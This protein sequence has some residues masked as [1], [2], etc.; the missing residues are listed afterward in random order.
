MHKL[1]PTKGGSH[2]EAD[3]KIAHRLLLLLD[4]KTANFTVSHREMLDGSLLHEK[5]TAAA[6]EHGLPDLP[7]VLEPGDIK[8]L[9][10]IVQATQLKPALRTA[11]PTFLGFDRGR[12]HGPNFTATSRGVLFRPC[13][14]AAN[15]RWIHPENPWDPEHDHLACRANELATWVAALEPSERLM[16]SVII[17]AALAWLQRG[18]RG[19]PSFVLL[20]SDAH[21]ELLGA[22]TGLV[23]IEVGR[24]PRLQ[25]GVPRLM[26]SS[27][28]RPDQFEKHGRIVAALEDRHRRTNPRIPIVL[29][30]W[31]GTSVPSPPAGILALLTH[32]V[33]GTTE[34]PSAV[35]RLISLVECPE[36]RRNFQPELLKAA[37]Y[38][39]DT[40]RYLDTFLAAARKLPDLENHVSG[41]ARRPTSAERP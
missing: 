12:F 14:A 30:R 27:Y 17:H 28:W 4:G 34:T 22:L 2:P 40:G 13:H 6:I 10:Q 37:N 29:H 21:L 16:V 15:A 41:E 7:R 33:L 25:L 36:L 18:S 38:W 20:P 19:L 35:I 23:P 9:P 8:R 1:L 3:R 11:P 32:C 39:A 5:A 26:R 31:T 24:G